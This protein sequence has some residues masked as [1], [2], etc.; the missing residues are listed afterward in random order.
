[1]RRR[2]VKA[3]PPATESASGHGPRPSAHGGTRS[4][5]P[6]RTARGSGGRGGRCRLGTRRTGRMRGAGRTRRFPGVRGILGVRR[7][8]GR[9]WHRGDAG[10]GFRPHQQDGAGGV[11]DDEAS[12]RPQAVRAEPGPVAVAG[13]RPAGRRPRRRR[14]P[15]ARPARHAPAG[16]RDRPAAL[17]PRRGVPR[18]TPF[19]AGPGRRPGPVPSRARP[20][21]P[22]KAPCAS[23]RYLRGRATCSST[24]SAASGAWVRTASTQA[25]QVP[26]TSQ[27]TTR[28]SISLR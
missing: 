10:G 8:L 15:R 4:R 2:S 24:T 25:R 7:V 13:Q 27:T 28:M 18:R 9:R 6:R 26:S 21:S 17:P 12:G 22:A 14:P 16:S 11:V 23:A 5:P 20:S 19:P 3:R 1:M